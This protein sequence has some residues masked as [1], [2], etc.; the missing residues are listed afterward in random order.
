[1]GHVVVNPA[2]TGT[3]IYRVLPLISPRATLQNPFTMFNAP[4]RMG[5]PALA[6][7]AF[8]TPSSSSGEPYADPLASSMPNPNRGYGEV[9]PWSSAPSPAQAA[10]PRR[11]SIDD[12]DMPVP[13]V[14]TSS[15]TT[16]DGLN[17]LISM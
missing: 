6:S 15:V 8:L 12:G 2:G 11:D 7:S 16:R 3:G 9:D 4:R 1:M 17:G 14:V 13:V 10:T 5:G